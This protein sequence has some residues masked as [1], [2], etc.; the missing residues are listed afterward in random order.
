MLPPLPPQPLLQTSLP[1]SLN[2]ELVSRGKVRDIYNVPFSEDL[3]KFY[4]SKLGESGGIDLKIRDVE[5]GALLFIATDRI[6]AYDVI[7]KNGISQKGILL[8]Q[9]SAFWFKELGDIVPNHVISTSF[10]EIISVLPLHPEEMTQSDYEDLK[11]QLK[12]RTMLVRKARVIPIE[13]IVR[14]Y[15]TG[16]AWSEYK[17]HST[18]HSIPV[19]PNLIESQKLPEPLFTPSTKADIG[20]HDENISPQRAREIIG[21]ELYDRVEEISLALYKRAASYAETKGL[22][23]ADTKFE[24]GLVDSE[25]EVSSGT[26]GSD[27]NFRSQPDG[28]SKWAPLLIDELLTPDSSR[29]WPLEGYQPGKPQPSFDKQ[30]LRDWMVMNGF[31]KGLESGPPGKDG[32][33][34]FIAAGIG[35]GTRQRYVD[36]VGRLTGTAN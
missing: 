11:T 13:A 23:L 36:C 33:G 18:V 31:K 3:A 12:G 19:P 25:P 5:Q 10:E 26:A 16:S 34:W 28:K 1:T 9:L 22:I 7:F 21:T 30:Y 8:T 32:E 20:M 2:L 24:F 15:L 17:A 35:E 4:A 29:Y 6:S 14:G 27:P